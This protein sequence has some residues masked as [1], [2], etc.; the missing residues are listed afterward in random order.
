MRAILVFVAAVAVACGSQPSMLKT[1][2]PGPGIAEA[3]AQERFAAIHDLRYELIFTVPAQR[4]T[5]IAGRMVARFTLSEPQPIVL[6]FAQPLHKLHAVRTGG[7]DTAFT[8]VEGHIV[9]AAADTVT[10]ANEIAVDFTSGDEPLNRNDEF[11]YTLFVP[12]RAHLAFPVFDQP[13]LKARYTLTLDVPDN[14]EAVSNGA[15]VE[16]VSA[17]GRKQVRFEETPPIPTYLFAFATGRFLVETVERDGREL[18]MFHRETDPERV[19]RNKAEVFDLHAA[20]LVWLEDYTA[21]SYPFAKFDFVAI[22]SFQF[23]GMEHPGVV[24]YDASNLLLDTSA[25]QNQRLERASLIAHETAHMWFGDLV[26]MQWFDDVW[27]KEVFANL[28]A[29]KIVNPSFSNIDHDLRFMLDHHPSAYDVDR[30]AG[31][32]PIRQTLDNLSDA[33]QMYG[34]IIYDKAPIAMRQLELVVGENTFREGLR[35]YLQTYAFRNATWLDLVQ[36][37]NARTS[38]D[39]AAWSRAW[40]EERG[41]PEFTVDLESDAGR[42][43]S[44]LTLQLR[45][46]IG[47][48]LIWPQRFSLE[49]G[50]AEGP[51]TVVVEIDGET[52][53]VAEAIGQERPQY[54]LPNADGLGYGLFALDEDSL[55]YLL[56]SIERLSTPLARGSAWVTLWDNLLEGRVAPQDLLDTAVRALAVEPNEQNVQ[57]ILGYAT[58]AFWKFLPPAERA[59]RVAALEAVFRRGLDAASTSSQKAAWFGAFRSVVLTDDGLLWLEQVWRRDVIIDGLELA[60]PDEM[61]IALELALRE[62]RGW[63]SILD[64]ELARIENP[65]RRDRFAFVMPALS[66]DSVV[67]EDAF[68]RLANPEV[69]RRE[70]WVVELLSYLHHPLREAHARQLILPALEMLP[71]IQRTGDIFF[72]TNWT[73]A[74]LGGH[75]SAEAAEIVQSFLSG[76]PQLSQRLRWTVLVAA[77]NLFKA[78]S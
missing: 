60:E 4:E 31:T 53:A 47:R 64:A 67:R 34:A 78:A 29:A 32:N 39:L 50:Y 44:A 17:S 73:T 5:L 76:E 21:I 10:G 13:D 25:T 74:T 14:W 11:L 36:I 19:V 43:I 16:T 68:A 6:D 30:T 48:G 28:M 35:E 40:I 75:R 38:L 72:P 77:D 45:D 3:L 26:T 69:R 18:R 70:A 59:D 55:G 8:F 20:A 54:V 63:S 66:A 46:P 9:I 22:P 33:G 7:R 71:E 24:L 42:R 41:R 15:V 62:V 61:A 52:T 23:G 37:L 56:N 12:A 1:D 49:L 51:V 27:M 2:T 58:R 65:D 57:R